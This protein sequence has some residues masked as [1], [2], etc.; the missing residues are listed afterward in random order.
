MQQRRGVLILGLVALAAALAGCQRRQVSSDACH[1][2]APAVPTKVT[3][4]SY[5]SHG[6]P[7]FADQMTKCS[8]GS[9]VVR[10]QMLPY[11]ELVNQAT[12]SMS[13]KS[14]SPYDIIHVYDQL[15]VEWAGK[16]WLAPLDDLVRKYWG[17]YHLDEIPAKLWD[18]MKVNGHI[19]AI[20]GI[21][22]PEIFL[23]RKDVFEKYGLKPPQT[24]DDLMTLC[25]ALKSKGIVPYPLLMMYSKSSD[26]VAYEFHDLIHSMGGRWFNDDGSPAFNGDIGQ[27]A[28][29][30]MSAL[31]HACVHPDAVNFTPEDAII[32]L[33]QGQFL[34]GILWVN[35]APQLDNPQLSKYAGNFGFA[36]APGACANCPPAAYWAQDSWVIPANAS[37]DRE[38]LFRIAMEGTQTKNQAKAAKI[39]LV[40][41]TSVSGAGQSPCWQAAMITIDR[42][43]VGLDRRTYAYLAREAI[44]RYA[45]EALL[46]HLTVKEA[47]DRAAADYSRAMHEEGFLK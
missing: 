42:G 17:Q 45:V 28:L 25:V 11:D 20:P 40:T 30:K 6:M 19:Y 32:G 14:P 37:V 36:P 44:T 2:P 15:L 22:N 31:Y 5:E 27:R 39:A 8:Q 46:G 21:Q 9:L 24:Y 13:A 1:V 10:H 43:A 47:L 7:F 18:M 34:M 26:H 23:Y 16:G 41:R 4:I 29:E 12:I 38:L 35:E 3:V 33:Q